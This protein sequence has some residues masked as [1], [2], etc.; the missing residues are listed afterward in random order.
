MRTLARAAEGSAALRQLPE[1][2]SRRLKNFYVKLHMLESITRQKQRELLAVRRQI[3]GL[4]VS[5]SQ[6]HSHGDI[7]ITTAAVP[8]FSP[9][10][11][12]TPR[13]QRSL[14]SLA[15]QSSSSAS[16]SASGVPVAGFDLTSSPI[17]GFVDQLDL[18]GIDFDEG[19]C[20]R[21]TPHMVPPII[22]YSNSPVPI[23]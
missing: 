18:S 17:A 19:D 21:T 14:G 23:P 1:I 3:S 13:A 10:F 4:A 16:A 11:S 15:S 2:D 5:R 7:D 20:D 8:S 12:A 6:S 22:E 9:D